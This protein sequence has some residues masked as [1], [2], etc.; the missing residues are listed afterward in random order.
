MVASLLVLWGLLKGC[1]SY[2]E[3]LNVIDELNSQ[4]KDT[5]RVDTVVRYDTV[6][7]DVKKYIPVKMYY[8]D[9]DT[10]TIERLMADTTVE[11][12]TDSTV[13]TDMRLTYTAYTAGR[14]LGI[15]FDYNIT[16]PDVVKTVTIDRMLP[17]IGLH[18]Y[19][20]IFSDRKVNDWGI[21]VG[22]QKTTDIPGMAIQRPTKSTIV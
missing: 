11:V 5:M 15:G 19:S 20:G 6:M 8:T 14:L 12:I 22:L 3:A 2:K 18:L 13:T 4:L 7:Y 17:D 10:V 16:R 21:S 9:T 1:S